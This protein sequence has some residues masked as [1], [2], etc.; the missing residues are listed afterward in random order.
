MTRK[1]ATKIMHKQFTYPFKGWY[2]RN[3]ITFKN[4]F[5]YH[6]FFNDHYLENTYLK[7]P[8]FQRNSKLRYSPVS[9]GI[10]PF[11]A[12]FEKKDISG[13]IIR[14]CTSCVFSTTTLMYDEAY[15]APFPFRISVA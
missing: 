12:Y 11:C 6:Y 4:S 3:L 9:F 13:K 14:I 10:T 2:S 7:I 15:L 1:M 8:I 5:I